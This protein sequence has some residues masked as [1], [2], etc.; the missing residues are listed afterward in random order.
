MT[1]KPLKA[2]YLDF[3]RLKILQHSKE[4][5]FKFISKNVGLDFFLMKISSL[6]PMGH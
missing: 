5:P 2:T 6:I 3:K 4:K 1:L